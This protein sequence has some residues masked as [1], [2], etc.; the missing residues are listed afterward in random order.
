M[1]NR[2]GKDRKNKEEKINVLSFIESH[3]NRVLVETS[4]TKIG[5]ANLYI[6]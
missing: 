4:G 5:Y 2:Q 3:E 1:E 6:Q